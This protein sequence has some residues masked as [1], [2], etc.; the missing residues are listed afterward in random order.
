LFYLLISTIIGNNKFKNLKLLLNNEHKQLIKKYIFPYKFISEQQQTIFLHKQTISKQQST[1]A[2]I[3]KTVDFSTLELQKQIKSS[4]IATE[5]SVEQLSLNKTLKKYKLKSGFYAG[6]N[7]GF[8]GSG[9]I[10]FY[11]GNII[12]LSSR[13]VLVFKK[14]IKDTEENFQQ[15]KHNIKEFIGINQFKKTIGFH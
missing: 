13:G 9:Y 5:E 7:T 6:I 14:N 2:D 4:E 10:E 8:P 12:V 11:K 15:I 3:L 1:I